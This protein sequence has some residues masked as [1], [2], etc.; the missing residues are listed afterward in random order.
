MIAVVDTN[1]LLDVFLP[2]PKY[3]HTSAALLKDFFDKGSLSICEI[4]YAE[5]VP[6][7]GNKKLL[8]DTLAKIKISISSIDEDIAFSRRRKMEPI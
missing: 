2:D 7:F 5:L 1:I 3:S 4:V 6:Q 8:D